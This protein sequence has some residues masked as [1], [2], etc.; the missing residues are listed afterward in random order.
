MCF[1]TC[2]GTPDGVHLWVMNPNPN[3]TP[4]VCEA[5]GEER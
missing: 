3:G 5:C 4:M 1:G 2:G